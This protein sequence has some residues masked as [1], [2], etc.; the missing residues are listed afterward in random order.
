MRRILANHAVERKTKKRTGPEA[1]DLKRLGQGVAV[2]G[3][4]EIL[5][6]D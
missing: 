3:V 4:D 5:A 6:V 1:A 2:R